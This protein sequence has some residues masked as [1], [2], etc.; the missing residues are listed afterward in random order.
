MHRTVTDVKQTPAK[1]D[2]GSRNQI[3]KPTT[4]F[5]EE[6]TKEYQ[7]VVKISIKN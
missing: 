3:Q 6:E 4:P 5:E 7:N 1:A 2:L